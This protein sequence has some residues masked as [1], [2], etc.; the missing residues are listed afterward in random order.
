MKSTLTLTILALTTTGVLAVD[1]SAVICK[2]KSQCA[3]CRCHLAVLAC[4]GLP[5]LKV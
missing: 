3:L 1:Y 2:D 5:L 4:F